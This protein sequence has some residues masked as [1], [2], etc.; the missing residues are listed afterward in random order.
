MI[1]SFNIKSLNFIRDSPNNRSLPGVAFARA[2]VRNDEAEGRLLNVVFR[3]G[4]FSLYDQK[5]E[6]IVLK[7]VLLYRRETR[8]NVQ[9]I[10][11]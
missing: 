11:F 6:Y 2:L 1:E 4:Q 9:R 3:V 7:F 8:S 5:S 10:E